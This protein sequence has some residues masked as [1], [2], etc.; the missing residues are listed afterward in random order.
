MVLN[1]KM[2]VASIS[3]EKSGLEFQISRTLVPHFTKREKNVN[4]YDHCQLYW[5]NVWKKEIMLYE[6]VC[7]LFF[8]FG[9]FVLVWF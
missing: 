9:F 5:A 1:S 3:G 2:S 6:H 8:L 4:H 7:L